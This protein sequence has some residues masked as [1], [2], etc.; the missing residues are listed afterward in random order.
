MA[1]KE[2]TEVSPPKIKKLSEEDIKAGWVTAK[3]KNWFEAFYVSD[4]KRC[5]APSCTVSG[6]W[7]KPC[8]LDKP[9]YQKT[10]K[11]KITEV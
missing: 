1:K 8:F 6:G 2:I 3:E 9:E 4:C 7:K 10:L 5:K 11:V